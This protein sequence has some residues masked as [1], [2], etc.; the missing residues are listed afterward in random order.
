[1][2]HREEVD[3]HHIIIYAD[4]KKDKI[5]VEIIIDGKRESWERIDRDDLYDN[6]ARSY[7]I[8]AGFMEVWDNFLKSKADSPAVIL[9]SVTKVVSY[10]HQ[11]S[12]DVFFNDNIYRLDKD[13]FI[14]S[15]SFVIWYL[16][17]FHRIP[18]IK[19]EE[20]KEFVAEILEMAEVSI[21]DPLGVDM[22]A[23]LVEMMQQSEIHTDFCDRCA[24]IYTTRGTSA[25]FVYIAE[26]KEKRF[27]L[28]VPSSVMQTIRHRADMGTKAFKN[29]WLPFLKDN[30]FSHPLGTAG[31]YE[32]RPQSKFWV[33]DMQKIAENNMGVSVV[34]DRLINCEKEC[35]LQTEEAV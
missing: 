31:I 6:P 16:G 22:L 18:L 2:L 25:W 19:E 10:D 12:A 29:Y 26:E 4:P 28:Y 7:L 20:W 35:R 13:A 32:K 30:T 9:N 23:M 34:F 14:S 11:F 27:R 8:N 21:Y 33:L 5:S 15:K 3:G 1:M 17:T 24:E